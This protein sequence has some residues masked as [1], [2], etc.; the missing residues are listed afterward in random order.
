MRGRRAVVVLILAGLSLAATPGDVGGCGTEPEALDTGAYL[1]ARKEQEC[2][3]CRECGIATRRCLRACDPAQ[4]P[5][6]NLP[7]T[8]RPLRHDGEVCLRAL[9]ASA[10][11]AFGTYVE[12]VAPAIPSECE[13]C[14]VVPRDGVP[15]FVVDAGGAE[16]G[17]TP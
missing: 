7:A 9:G 5:D 1:L 10:C 17:S 2:S 15:G 3:R 14:K 8:C 16:G 4:P 6:T 13:F 12:D 11:D